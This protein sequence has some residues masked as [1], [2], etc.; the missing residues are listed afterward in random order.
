MSSLGDIR[1]PAAEDNIANSFYVYSL[2]AAFMEIGE[3]IIT[4]DL[5][6]MGNTTLEGTTDLQ[7]DA[8]FDANINISTAAPS[9]VLY[10]DS[11][12][13]LQS[14]QLTN[15]QLQIGSTGAN[16]AIG[17][18]TG[19][20]GVTVTNGA[21]SIGVALTNF[22][23][24]TT[25]VNILQFGGAAVGL[26]ATSNMLVY[27]RISNIIFFSIN[28]VLTGLGSSTGA[29]TITLPVI[30]TQSGGIVAS[31][32]NMNAALTTTTT[33][34][35]VP[36]VGAHTANVDLVTITGNTGQASNASFTATSVILCN[37]IY[38]C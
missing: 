3:L 36:N 9:S 35:I 18:I 26:T 30:P 4:G 29:A 12:R 38:L 16:P 21:G 14:V 24:P 33:V 1:F 15:G 5:T 13:D 23:G 32:S 6:V 22:T 11:S 25:I 7:G 37:G 8:T 27:Y 31:C 17:T 34:S 10:L 28:I 19:T 20:N 2:T